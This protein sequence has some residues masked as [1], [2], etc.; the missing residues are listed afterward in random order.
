MKGLNIRKLAAV[1]VGGALVGSA[2]A[3]LAAAI[4]IT[5]ADVIGASGAPVV[6]IVAGIN[7]DASDFVWAGN[8]AAKVAQLATVDTALTGGEG[9][10]TPS[11]LS[12]DLAVGGES[13]YS[14]EYAKT[15]DGTNYDFNNMSGGTE[16]IKM[17]GHGQLPFLYNASKSYRW[18]GSTYNTTIKE[19][20]GIELDVKFA[21]DDRDIKDL[22]G[23]M[24]NTGDF[25]YVLDLGDGIPSQTTLASS[26]K[27]TDGT[28]DNIII[29]FLGEEFT[30]QEV[31]MVSSPRT[32]NL[33]KES[34]KA[35]YNEGDTIP[36]LTGRASY[37]GEEMSVKI[38]AVTQTSATATYNTRFDLYDSE[39][40]LVDSQTVGAGDYLNKNFLD[41]DGSYAL[42]TVIYV[43]EVNIE[44]TTSKGVLTLIVGKNVVTIANAK[45]YPYDETNTDTTT[46]YWTATIDQNSSTTTVTAPTVT[47]I[48]IKNR[49]TTWNSQ[50]PLWTTLSSLTEAGEEEAAA[51]GDTAHF[52][53]GEESKLG[54]DFVKVKLKGF[55]VDQDRTEIIVGNNQLVYTDSEDTE[56]TIPFYFVLDTEPQTDPEQQTIII[57][58]QPFYAK[59]NYN[60]DGVNINVYDGNRLN[61][62]VFHTCNFSV[63]N[64]LTQYLPGVATDNGC[65]GINDAN[66]P[67]DV[68]INGVRFTVT[69]DLNAAT[70]WD[71]NG[72]TLQVDGNCS[73]AYNEEWGDSGGYLQ[74]GGN[75]EISQI[76]NP[77]TSIKTVYF[78]DDNVTRSPGD[79]AIY[80]TEDGTFVDTYRY[81]QYYSTGAK[82]VYMLLDSSTS[83]SNTYAGIADVNF[84]GTDALERGDWGPGVG[85]PAGEGLLDYYWPDTTDFKN[86]PSDT[87]YLVAIFG[88][89]GHT[90]DRDQFRIHVDTYTDDLIALPNTDRSN[91]SADVNYV[92]LSGQ[93]NWALK[94]RTDITDALHSG[95]IDFGTTAELTDDM[96]TATFKIPEAQIY[97]SASILGEG[98]TQVVAG[99]ETEEGVLEGETVTIAG[100]DISVSKI[101]YTEG[102]CTVEGETYAKIVQVGQLVYTDSPAPAG[103]HIIVGGY[104]VNKLAESVVLGDGSTL[105]EA[106]TAPGDSV[107]EVL[108]GG[109]IIV[110]GYTA[111][112]TKTAAQELINALEAL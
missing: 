58:D 100:K 72:A 15:Y 97:L 34:S 28:N 32:I 7:A 5:K 44:P 1:V 51:G 92:D 53:Q 78:D 104:M 36:G 12:V 8:I 70:V 65:I 31:D 48:T 60:D 57:D 80:F 77:A 21:H 45:Q 46:W 17:P 4:D 73:Y 89:Q 71:A 49:T 111:T 112:D 68:D 30:V 67:V 107:A 6:N 3:P 37:A 52:L 14:T 29:P 86:D 102:T 23:F 110:A 9:T 50:N 19:T 75:A 85:T 56:R 61:G 27:F 38:S 94:A 39:G 47:K 2:L 106:L 98:A 20:I 66:Q 88:V 63:I 43:S 109:N 93:P 62:A 108:G 84:I 24:R 11:G 22:V 64:S 101:N 83:F 81:K 55:K 82:Q 59:C 54:Y 99:G 96:T 42:E 16:F 105:Q 10:A 87:A 25:N 76:G 91:Y 26:V 74:V 69:A 103:S 41:A 79:L 33:I 13:S 90:T 95:I 35:T 18:E 40:N